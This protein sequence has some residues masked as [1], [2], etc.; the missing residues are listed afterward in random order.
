MHDSYT[1][2]IR[3]LGV[4]L[5]V[6]DFGTGFSS[7]SNLANLPVTEVKIDRSFIDKC[8]EEKRLQ[9]LVTA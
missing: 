2:R 8:L 7:L 1:R 9:S 4:G 6:D 3:E 5:S